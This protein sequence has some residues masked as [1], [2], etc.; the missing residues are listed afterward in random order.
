LKIK[1]SSASALCNN[2]IAVIAL[3]LNFYL[4]LL[5]PIPKT[6]KNLITTLLL[7]TGLFFD[8]CHKDSPH[9][10]ATAPIVYVAGYE[11]NSS[12][13]NVAK[14]WKNGIATNLT[15]GTHDASA[16][17][18]FVNGADV[19][20]AGYEQNSNGIYMTKLWKNGV[21]TNLTDSTYN[22]Y[23]NSVYVSGSDVYV[24][25]L[26]IDNTG[27][28]QTPYYGKTVYLPN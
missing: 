12:G 28:Y 15:D 25:G 13:V 24:A 17:S 9:T 2:D 26:E 16:Q 22:V 1:F 14:L 19:Y 4:S 21:A 8:S 10:S 23:A 27:L 3:S 5:C 20:A 11:Q 7:T 18:V 6:M